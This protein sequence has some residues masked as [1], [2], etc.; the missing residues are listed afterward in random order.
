MLLRYHLVDAIETMKII[1]H[2]L[3][4]LYPVIVLLALIIGC[5]P[6]TNS[7]EGPIEPEAALSTFELEPGYKIELIASEPLVVGSS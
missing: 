7:G 2:Y 4:R 6:Q 3:N 5:T 1:L